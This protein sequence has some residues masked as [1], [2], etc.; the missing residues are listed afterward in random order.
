[1]W[2]VRGRTLSHLR[3]PA[4]WAGCRGR[5]GA[6]GVGRS[7]TP[8][9]PP[10]GR[11]AGAG[12][13]RPGLDA[14]PTPTA[15][16]L[17]GLPRP[18]WCVRGQAPSHPRLLAL[19]A[20]CR[21][22]CGASGVGR[23]P[24]PDCSPSG[25][26]AG[27]GVGRSGSG[28]L[29]PLTARPL[30][31]LPG[32]VWGVRGRVL[33]HPRLP[34]LW[35]GCRGRCGASGVGRSPTPDCSPSGRAAGAGVGRPGSDAL[36]PPTTRPLGGL[37]GPLW[38][39]RGRALSHPRLP[40]LWAG[41]RGR[42]G[43][44]GV[45]S[46]PTP[47]CLPS[48]R[49]AGA[50]VARPGSSALPAPTARPLGGLPGPEW[51]DRGLAL[52]HPRLPA[53]WAGC[54]GRCGT[55]GS[56]ALPPPTA[57]P[58]GGLPG[59]V[60]GVR[61]R[62]LSHP[63]L[64]AL[65]AGCRGWCMASGVGHSPTPDC[66]P[67]GRAAGAG[68]GRPT[69]G[70]RPPPTARP[71]G[72]LPGPVWGD[73]GRALSHP[74]LPALWAGCRGRC[75]A[76]GVGRSP[77]PNCPPSGRAAGP[78]VGRPRSGALPPPTARPLGG[79]P[80]QVWG[81]RGRTLS[82]PRLPALWARC[83]GRC[84]ASGVGRSPTPDC[85][86]SGRATG[87][88]VG[89]PGLDALP[90][91][92]ARPLGGLPGPVWG[93]RGRALSQPRLPAL[94]AGCRGR[95][96]ASRVGRS[97]TPDCPPS[98]RAAGAGVGRPGS[99]ALPTP[100]AR[101]P[102]G[103]PGPV[104]GV[105][106]RAL[107]QPR[108][109]PSGRAAGAGVG[110]PGSDALPPPTARPL[111]GLPGPVWGVRGRALSRPRLPAPWA[112]CWGRCGASGVG[113]SPT[114]D[115]PPSGRA[116]GAGAG[117][118]G[119]DAFPPPTAR[120]LG[121][122][123]GPVWGVRGRTLSHTRL[124]ALWAGC[125]GQYGASG[126]GRSPTPDCPPS[127]RA[128]GADVGRPGSGALPPPTACPLGGLTGP[129]WGVRGRT[130]SNPRLPALWAGCRGRCGAS[131]VGRSPTPDCPPSGRAAGAGVGRPGWD[132]LPPPTARP[133][134][135]LPGPVWGV[136]GQ[137]LSLP[138]LLALWAGCRGRCGASGVGSSPTPDCP[139]SGRA[140]GA[141]LGRPGSDALPP[142]TARP[143]GGL[144]GPV[145][146]VRGRALSHARLLTLCA[147]CRGPC[148]ASGVGRSPTPDCPPSGRPAGA[149]VGLPGSDALPPP[150]VRPLGG[151][152]GPVWGVRGR[153]LFHP[154]LPALWA[155]CRGRCGA[156]GVESAPTPDCSPSG[157]AAGAG[158]GRPESD[159]LPP[160]TARP[161]GGLPGPVWGVRGRTLS[162][163]QPPALWAGCGVAVRARAL[164]GRV[165]RAGLPGAFWCASP[166][167]WPFLLR[168]LLVRPPPGWGCP[169]CGCCWV[170][171]FFFLPPLCAPRC[172]LLCV[173]S[174]L[175]CPGP[176]RPVASPPPPFF[177]GPPPLP[178]A[179]VSPGAVLLCAVL[180]CCAR[181]VPALVVPCPLAL[182]VALGPCALR[183]CV[184][185]YS[186]SLC[187]FCRGVVVRAVV[188][189]S[190]L[191]CVC[192][193]VLCCAFPVLS[194]LCGAVLCCAAALALCCS[195]GA[196]CSWC[197]VLWCAAVCCGV[198]FGVL[199]CGAGSG[200]PWLSA[201]AVLWRPAVHVPLL[202]VLV[203]VF[204][205]CVRCCVAL[206]VVL[207][208]AGV[209][210]AVVGASC[211]ALWCLP[212]RSALWWCCSGCRGVLLCCALS[213]GN[214]R[215]VPFPAVPCCPAVLCWLAVLCGCLRCWCLFFLLSSFPLLKTPA[216]FPC[217]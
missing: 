177:F 34:A 179:L 53:P 171:F 152:P 60:W 24:S 50:H 91:L 188:R 22:R 175:G 158:V 27:A 92:T 46:A 77:T 97:P 153:T 82:H 106:G 118:P 165:G 166:F 108:C 110:R 148:G 185:R 70:A 105:R 198:S 51:G 55:S 208:G 214:L 114:P 150:T 107:S 59:P 128:A 85:P 123:P 31:G 139:A 112:G 47:D 7:P 200:G 80:G 2:G 116:A 127:G 83:Q 66:P 126:V 217:L 143:L 187:V 131:R 216:V 68:V 141:G 155:G 78:V 56:G 74:R 6:S 15:R 135:G 88:G 161:L 133:L 58:L 138:R 199:W 11:A 63:R 124:P 38:G 36:P 144:P 4:L 13:G 160:P 29:P 69:S 206:R 163:P 145:W 94:R 98:G 45:G 49:A 207:F 125:R 201:G 173:F 154:R 129:V 172:L 159:A 99:G 211:C 100:T 140:A 26:A 190:A 142:P 28:A 75:G 183:C 18:V 25:R 176:W 16:P 73:R 102:G 117:R 121:G 149:G 101:P 40:A 37:P 33:S 210:C 8:D 64:L 23:S 120:P 113:H 162:H 189:R 12:V 32:P 93:V 95:C 1:M 54:R 42:C 14:L 84:G 209:V 79:L 192:P 186:P 215:P 213:C 67:S 164:L 182:P 167:L 20:G 39:V 5:C 21:G 174:G 43:A 109:P 151:L 103:L 17:G 205:L 132:A 65:W 19:L 48:A 111:G 180:F 191:C 168:S 137:T 86:P 57:R 193:G 115:C 203:C 202:V 157:R 10:S 9:C 35:A 170:F 195:C 147:G 62:A 156:S 212:G 72:G 134:G 61:R 104:W 41:C 89:R 146:G 136:Q 87:A 90:C 178:A 44:S 204:S 71:L 197:L 194:A 119:S 81:V 76:S 122:L 130:L 52:S 169:V 96:R 196:C 184:F 30:G 3:L 181:L